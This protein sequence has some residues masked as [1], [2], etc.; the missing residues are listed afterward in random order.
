MLVGIYLEKTKTLNQKDT[1]TPML[2][3]ALFT[4]AKTWKQP[5][6]ARIDKWIRKTHTHTQEQYS[7]IKSKILSFAATWMGLKKH[8][9]EVK[10]RQINII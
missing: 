7:V 5:R 2:K 10:Q 9:S 1:F 3:A 6:C 4:V 8:L